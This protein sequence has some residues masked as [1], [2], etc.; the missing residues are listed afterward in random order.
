MK[1]YLVPD[2]GHRYN[3]AGTGIKPRPR[4]PFI[5]T[6]GLCLALPPGAPGLGNTTTRARNNPGRGRVA[7][8]GQDVA[9]GVRSVT[10]PSLR[11]R[12]QVMRKRNLTLSSIVSREIYPCALDDFQ[13]RA[14]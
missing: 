9:N 14:Q 12:Q 6:Q 11:A 4:D 5:S 13:V 1:F 10:Q 2:V 8:K 3:P 7:L